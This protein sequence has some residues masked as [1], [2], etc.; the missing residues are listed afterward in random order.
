[1]NIGL[2]FLIVAILSSILLLI[3][4]ISATIAAI[5]VSS[6]TNYNG[7]ENLN[8]AHKYLTIS[9]ALGWSSLATLIVI[10][11]MVGIA[12][13]YFQ[14]GYDYA[15]QFSKNPNTNDLAEAYKEKKE[16]LSGHT[17][18]IITLIFLI[19]IIIVTLLVGIFSAIAAAQIQSASSN[20]TN[21]NSTSQ[22]KGYAAAVVAAVSAIGGTGLLLISLIIF[23]I[24]DRK[25]KTDLK[26]TEGYIKK[27]EAELGIIESPDGRLREI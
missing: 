18:Q 24:F 8:N 16:L 1:M 3:A 26:K 7:N 13:G 4:S 14:R 25:R 10:M 6:N 12:G 2:W 23:I 21:T 17:A 20:S 11:I 22:T 27:T 15:R 5:Q 9:A 19:L